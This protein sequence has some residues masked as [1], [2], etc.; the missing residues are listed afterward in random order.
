MIIAPRVPEN[1]TPATIAMSVIT[2]AE[3]RQAFLPSKRPIDA[4]EFPVC[5]VE[6]LNALTAYESITLFALWRI[7]F[8]GPDLESIK[9]GE[10]WDPRIVRIPGAC[11][12]SD[13]RGFVSVSA[14]GHE[15]TLGLNQWLD[16]NEQRNI[17]FDL[18]V[19]KNA[20]RVIEYDDSTGLA[21]P[22]NTER[23]L[24]EYDLSVLQSSFIAPLRGVEA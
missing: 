6:M 8:D 21:A 5:V 17:A 10:R 23:V 16:L 20:V 18:A 7:P 11:V 19:R 1:W 9:R 15:V 14:D 4:E 12:A 24:R 2:S 3:G 13:I 22:Y